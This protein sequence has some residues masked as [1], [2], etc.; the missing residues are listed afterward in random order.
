VPLH[1]VVLIIHV[2]AV[3]V[4]CSVLSIEGLSLVHLRGASTLAEVHPWIEPVRRLRFFAIGSVLAIQ[5]S[6]AYLVFRTS[7]LDQAWPKVAMVALPV[8]IAPFGNLTARRMRAI[9]EAFRLQKPSN[10]ELFGMLQAPFLKISLGIRIAAFLGIFLLVSVKPGLW[11]SII[12]VGASLTISLL[13]SFLP[14]RR[15]KGASSQS[16]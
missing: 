13:L 12:L 11:G 9:R 7:S 8:F 10:S 2:I 1:S 3:F 4:L 15:S 6:G 14:W 16:A 5:F